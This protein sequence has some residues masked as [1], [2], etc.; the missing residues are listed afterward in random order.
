MTTWA[1]LALLSP[2][3]SSLI[4]GGLLRVFPIVSAGNDQYEMDLDT[5]QPPYRSRSVMAHKVHEATQMVKKE[6]KRI[7]DLPPIKKP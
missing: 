5:P 3:G 4:V 2:V 6:V 1:I 7:G